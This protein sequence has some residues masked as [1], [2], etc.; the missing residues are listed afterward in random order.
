MFYA[1]N[2]I[3]SCCMWSIVGHGILVFDI[4]AS[5]LKKIHHTCKEKVKKDGKNVQ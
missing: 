2:Q 1:T 3:D 5:K 4:V